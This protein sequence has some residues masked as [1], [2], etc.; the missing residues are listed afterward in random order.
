MVL[1]LMQPV[2]GSAGAPVVD[3]FLS[4]LAAH[5]MSTRPASGE[6][7]TNYAVLAGRI[8]PDIKQAP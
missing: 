3:R 6:A 8:W 2:P 4:L 5:E 1:T 7:Q